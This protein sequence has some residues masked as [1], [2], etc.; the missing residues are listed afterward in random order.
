MTDMPQDGNV[1]LE[2]IR[3]AYGP[4]KA[5]ARRTPL[6]TSRTLDVMAGGAVH[7]KAENLQKTGSFKIRGAY[8]ALSRLSAAEREKGVVTASA[9]NHAQGIA[10]AAQLT[11]IRARV[12]MP[13]GASIAKILAT[14]GYGADVQLAGGS[15]DEAVAAAQELAQNTGAPFISAF[16]H[17]DII[18]GQGSVGLELLED[19]PDVDTVLIPVGGGGLISGM[20]IALKES[21]PSLRVI[22]VQAEGCPAA[23]DSWRAGSVVAAAQAKTIADGIAVKKPSP[24]TLHYLRKYVDDMVTVGDEEIA[25]T[26]V[27]LMERM[28]ILV[29]GAGAV[30]LTALIAR[31]AVPKGRTAVVLSG[32]NID[33]KLLESLIERSMI[34]AGRYVRLFTAVDDRPGGLARL[35]KMIAEQQGNII[36]VIHNRTSTTVPIGMTGVEILIETRDPAHIQALIS[37]MKS[38]AYPV[39]LIP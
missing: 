15:F 38:A 13:L 30:A 39:Q 1:T 4:L 8:T 2:R 3:E 35:L 5:V 26:I 6:L 37:A 25:T 32:G 20:A 18:T 17:D 29:E 12:F 31:K 27:T 21:R 33:I 23:T 34:R 9:G 19:L 28:K 24:R 22:G 11:G 7:L 16:D 14:R 36:D 10:L